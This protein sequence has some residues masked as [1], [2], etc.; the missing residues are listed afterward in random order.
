MTKLIKSFNARDLALVIAGSFIFGLGCNLF[1]VSTGIY[2]GGIVGTSQ[3]IR[4]V[5]VTYMGL[6]TD[7]D[8]AGIINFL[9][10]IPLLIIA[11]KVLKGPFVYKTLLSVIVQT[12]AFSIIPTTPVIDDTLASLIIGGIISGVGAGMVLL[13]R[14]SAGGN[15]ITGMLLMVKSPKMSVGKV[16][17]FY[18]VV[19][20][21][22]CA[23]LFDIETAIYS[24][25]QAAVFA[26]AIDKTH[27]QNIEVSIMIFTRNKDVKNTIIKDIH[28]GVTYWKG[29][30]AYTD[31]ETEVLVTIVSK[32]EVNNLRKK[33]KSLD[34]HAFVI[35]FENLGT[36]D[37]NVE[38]RLI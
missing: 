22:V 23:I 26:F 36:V 29:L 37:G 9:I 1:V 33:V 13:A 38:K 19:L 30:G 6:D 12:I 3:V 2:N 18:N 31:S 35:V 24:V 14:A 32:D 20:Y 21:I 34:E 17:L 7:F 15:D 25:I 16:N 10:N 8:I 5:L 27:L 28:R 4:S 11:F